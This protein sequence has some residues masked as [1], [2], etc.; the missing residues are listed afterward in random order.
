MTQIDDTD[1]VP[2]LYI[3]S[4]IYLRRGLMH[5]LLL[6]TMNENEGIEIFGPKNRSVRVSMYCSAPFG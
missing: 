3:S 4:T 2:T 6:R 1:F 5:G